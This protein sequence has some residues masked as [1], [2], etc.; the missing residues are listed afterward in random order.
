LFDHE[1]NKISDKMVEIYHI[2]LYEYDNDIIMA[3]ENTLYNPYD[4]PNVPP[5]GFIFQL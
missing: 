1:N 5:G 4:P 3:E 2:Y